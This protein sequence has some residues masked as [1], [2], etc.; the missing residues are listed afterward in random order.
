MK[1]KDKNGISRRKFIVRSAGSTLAVGFG[2]G[3]S[4]CQTPGG[5][6]GL[7][8][9]EGTKGT[10]G[11]KVTPDSWEA[12]GGLE[13][14][15][16]GVGIGGGGNGNNNSGQVTTTYD[17][18]TDT[19]TIE[20]LTQ[21]DIVILR[22]GLDEI[23]GSAVNLTNVEVTLAAGQSLSATEPNP[24]SWSITNIS[25]T[26]VDLGAGYSLAPNETLDIGEG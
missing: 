8:F 13:F 4:S 11:Y 17:S 24:D 19:Y 9:P 20:N 2:A 15:L 18:V 6:S 23:D 26:D 3:L 21:E 22:Y 7:R 10:L 12:T 16:G 14:P 1:K 25:N 5:G